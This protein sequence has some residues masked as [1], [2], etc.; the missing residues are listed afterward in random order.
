MLSTMMNRILQYRNL[1]I[2]IRERQR[3]LVFLRKMIG[4]LEEIGQPIDNPKKNLLNLM[5]EIKNLQNRIRQLQ[6][7][8]RA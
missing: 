6:L 7:Q 8:K 3:R 2:Q 1:F 4:Q 5:L